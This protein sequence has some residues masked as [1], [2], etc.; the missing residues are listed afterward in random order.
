MSQVMYVVMAEE[1]PDIN[2]WVIAS[3]TEYEHA[4]FFKQ[5]IE[6]E[7]DNRKHD[8]PPTDTRLSAEFH[9]K[10][11][12]NMRYYSNNKYTFWVQEIQLYAHYD[13]FLEEHN[14]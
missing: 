3:F 4:L 10:Y 11:D 5:N 1:H 13:Q 6:E 8:H 9:N 14:I 12:P 2:S 7:V